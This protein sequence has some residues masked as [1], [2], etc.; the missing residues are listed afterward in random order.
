MEV[1]NEYKMSNI[2]DGGGRSPYPHSGREPEE[3]KSRPLRTTRS[4]SYAAASRGT[5]LAFASSLPSAC[6]TT[7]LL[8]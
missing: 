6:S 5:T 4:F 3:Y 2:E 1:S 8:N 7:S